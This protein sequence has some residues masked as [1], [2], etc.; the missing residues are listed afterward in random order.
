MAKLQEY[1]SKADSKSK[2][3]PL[4]IHTET[5][6]NENV[7]VF[8]SKK[9]KWSRN[10]KHQ[11]SKKDLANVKNNGAEVVEEGVIGNLKGIDPLNRLLQ[12]AGLD[13]G[14]VVKENFESNDELEEKEELEEDV[15]SISRMIN[16]EYNTLSNSADYK[17]KKDLAVLAT[18]ANVLE[19]LNM[20]IGKMPSIM[21]DGVNSQTAQAIKNLPAIGIV[22]KK[23]LAAPGS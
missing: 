8:N 1:F 19:G 9:D 12:L 23:A 21:P 2:N 15:G 11:L 22:I 13:S 3:K 18:I 10:A 4:R 20:M 14:P 17:D 7:G 6:L 16:T 5:G